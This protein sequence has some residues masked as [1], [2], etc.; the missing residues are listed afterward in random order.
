MCPTYAMYISIGT[1]VVS[2]TVCIPASYCSGMFQARLH[3]SLL[4]EL[5][6]DI[7]SVL[8]ESLHYTAGYFWQYSNNKPASHNLSIILLRSAVGMTH[9][10]RSDL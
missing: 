3:H 7:Y 8:V 9:S 10:L 4:T 6:D 5:L 1:P 2:M